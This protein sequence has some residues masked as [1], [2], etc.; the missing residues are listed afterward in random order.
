MTTSIS[1]ETQK[2]YDMDIWK[3]LTTE[4]CH[5]KPLYLIITKPLKSRKLKAKKL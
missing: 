4:Q 1:S 2:L 3:K 5:T